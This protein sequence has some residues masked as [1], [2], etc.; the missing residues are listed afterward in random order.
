MSATQIAI[1]M[2][3]TEGVRSFYKGFWPN[4][5]RIGTFNTLM[6]VFYE[7]INSLVM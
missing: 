7:K 2:L 4:F 3:K 1:R 5:S 6:W